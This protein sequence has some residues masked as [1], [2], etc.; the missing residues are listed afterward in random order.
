MFSPLEK[1]FC[2]QEPLPDIVCRLPICINPGIVLGAF[3]D[4]T[5]LNWNTVN[6]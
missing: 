6:S 4:W 2:H 1:A 5:S 3:C